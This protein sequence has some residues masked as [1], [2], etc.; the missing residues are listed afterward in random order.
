M[1]L[2]RQYSTFGIASFGDM[3]ES[4]DFLKVDEL[5][6]SYYTEKGYN[7]AEKIFKIIDETISDNNFDF[8]IAVRS[9]NRED[10][11]E[12]ET[13]GLFNKA[14]VIRAAITDPKDKQS[15]IMITLLNFEVFDQ[16]GQDATVRSIFTNFN[17]RDNMS[18]YSFHQKK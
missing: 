11:N 3:M 4:F 5:G 10:S 17:N 2:D 8:M 15:A 13:K 7:F 18:I 14:T 6:N 1:K 9:L 12:S 16:D